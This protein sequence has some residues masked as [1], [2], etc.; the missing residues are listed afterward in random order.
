[1][2]SLRV[3]FL[4]QG[5]GRGHLTQAL[6]L[7]PMLRR[8]GHRVV[9]A[10][11]GT[12][13]HRPL[14]PFFAD[15]LGAPVETFDEPGFAHGGRGVA[16]G[17]TVAS[18]FRRLP[19]LWRSLRTLDDA[20]DRYRPDVVVNFYTL[21]GGLHAALRRAAPP[22]VCVGHQYFFH[23]PAYPF[24]ADRVLDRV[25][26]QR[27]TALTALGAARRLALSFYDAPALPDQPDLRVVPPLLRDAV[28]AHAPRDDGFLL[29]Y[30][31]NAGYAAE[32][33][34][35]SAAHPNVPVHCF[36]DA[37]GQSK[38]VAA[39]PS[40][41]FHPLSATRFLEM[42]ARCRGL[43]C[44]AGFESVCEAMFLG[45]PAL[46][47]PVEGH[48]EQACNARDA[49][50]VG[51]GVHADRFDLSRLLDAAQTYTGVPGFRA[52][53]GRAEAVFVEEIEQA[54]RAARWAA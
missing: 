25:V 34:A 53:V 47:V 6:A 41:T 46:M 22:L 20:L 24:P 31:L 40:L 54:A 43:V 12:N 10:C 2:A 1:M 44:T 38:P 16:M 29:A 52:W 11:V 37:P 32:V 14:A 7:A 42:M 4:V 50:A 51:A 39:T 27:Y 48:F 18:T 17:A 33:R 15:A 21:L 5:E 26:A 49:E 8:A 23:H 19:A 36:C 28:Q 13:P 35:W 3:L 30:L 45:K 9:A